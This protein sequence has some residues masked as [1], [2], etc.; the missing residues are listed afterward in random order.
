MNTIPICSTWVV[1]QNIESR[2]NQK[3]GSGS[4]FLG[5]TSKELHDGSNIDPLLY[6][7]KSHR[8][9]TLLLHIS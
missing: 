3:I 6:N 8:T 9:T 4:L 2:I 7:C 1:G 5:P